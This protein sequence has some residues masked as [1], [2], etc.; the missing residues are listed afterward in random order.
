MQS[1]LISPSSASCSNSR[2]CSATLSGGRARS[3]RSASTASECCATESGAPG[4]TEW[5][6]Q[7]KVRDR[8]MAR[9]SSV[10]SKA[11]G[12]SR[13]SRR[14]DGRRTQARV[15]ARH[16]VAWRGEVDGGGHQQILGEPGGDAGAALAQVLR[17]PR[18]VQPHG[19]V[20]ARHQQACPAARAT[21]PRC[22]RAS[23]GSRRR[24]WS[25]RPPWKAAR[26]G[27]SPRR[28]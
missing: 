2:R 18:L 21:A 27:S 14:P 10:Q 19:E 23:G 26:R 7:R 12:D 15:G 1:K 20:V 9:S 22:A 5:P 3:R 24:P 13:S 8:P 25:C 6:P 11:V 4:H 28:R 16:S 17:P